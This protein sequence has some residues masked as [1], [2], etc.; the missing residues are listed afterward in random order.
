[1]QTIKLKQRNLNFSIDNLRLLILLFVFILPFISAQS[2][3]NG[4]IGLNATRLVYSQGEES[5]SISA[6]NN[7]S[8]ISC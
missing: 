2:F 8:I 3:A 6:R 1:M 7:T 5:I 4:G